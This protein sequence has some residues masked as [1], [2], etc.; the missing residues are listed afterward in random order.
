MTMIYWIKEMMAD[1]YGQ[2]LVWLIFILI[3]MAVDITT[4]FM[5]AWIN[6]NLK[7]RKMSEGILKKTGLLLVLVAVVP[8]T[9]VLPELI[10]TSVILVV[11]GLET[12]N[13]LI[14][15]SENLKKMGVDV[16]ILNPIIRRLFKDEGD[17]RK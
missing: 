12:G 2:L 4:G 8:F 13:E 14:S 1:E 9:F 16:K 17:G 6:H 15:I 5:Q 3:M 11:Y 7:S 10:S